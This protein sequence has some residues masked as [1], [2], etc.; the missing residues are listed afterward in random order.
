MYMKQEDYRKIGSALMSIAYNLLG[1]EKKSFTYGT[2]VKL[3]ASEIFVLCFIKEHP[4]H[5]LIEIAK[6]LNV[7]RGA[8]SQIVK[9]L[10]NKGLVRPLDTGNRKLV[11]LELTRK[12]ETAYGEHEKMNIELLSELESL[13]EKYSDDE[14][15]ML[16][17]YTA[18]LEEVSDVISKRYK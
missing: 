13:F 18:K 7:T 17:E 5:H 8:V 9:K 1:G 10:R 2:D 3:F 6:S 14:T 16:L 15:K 4:G 12:G 11:I